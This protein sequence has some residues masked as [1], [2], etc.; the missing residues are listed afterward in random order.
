MPTTREIDFIKYLTAVQAA[1]N[2]IA[3]LS[4]VVLKFEYRR[5]RASKTNSRPSVGPVVDGFLKDVPLEV[6]KNPG[7]RIRSER[8]PE[9]LVRVVTVPRGAAGFGRAFLRYLALP[10]GSPAGLTMAPL[11]PEYPEGEAI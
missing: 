2:G 8:R 4:E 7:W 11:A 5:F 9:V 6:P 10:D 3:S 1:Y